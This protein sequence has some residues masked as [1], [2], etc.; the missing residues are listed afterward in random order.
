MKPL[1]PS[2]RRVLGLTVA[3]V[4]LAAATA[5]A[6][7]ATVPVS[8][9]VV[10]G[11]RVLQVT[12]TDTAG[13]PAGPAAFAFGPNTTSAPFG[14]VVSDAMYERTGYEVTATL[15]DLIMVDEDTGDLRCGT[16]VP[17]GALEVLHAAALDPADVDGVV[18]SLLTFHAEDIRADVDGA[19]TGVGA[20][21]DVT[22]PSVM[23]VTVPSVPGAVQDLSSLP[24]AV[25]DDL[26]FMTVSGGLG[27]PFA[28]AAVHPRCPG[29]G[30][31]TATAVPLQDGTPNTPDLTA[32]RTAIFDAAATDTSL[33]APEAIAAGLLP[34]GSDVPGG[35]LYEATKSAIA[36]SLA[37]AGIDGAVIES[38]IDTVTGSVI[39]DLTATTTD[40]VLD[41]IGQTGVYAN[42]PTL[43]VD[44]E[45]VSD[46]A[47]GLYHG[48][49]TVTLVDR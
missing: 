7:T 3:S 13:L 18:E 38:I 34:P 9:G 19:L 46:A 11:A 6:D 25:V 39:D 36:Q 24:G 21:L 10:N 8:L 15:S 47:T 29:S 5:L 41:L 31:A 26:T 42:V 20:V 30:D 40:L 22:L 37:E 35:V 17:A 12:G 2:P 27:G 48:V 14:V 4:V 23:P 33:D 28:D 49:M 32:V 44:P 43:S 1:R 45:Q 16:T